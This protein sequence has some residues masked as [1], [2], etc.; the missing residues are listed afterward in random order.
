MKKAMVLVVVLVMMVQGAF[1]SSN[2]SVDGIRV[3]SEKMDVFYFKVS[4]EL[5]GAS[6][7]VIDPNGKQILVDQVDNRKVLIDFYAEPSGEYTIHI[8]KDS[9]DVSVVYNK[10]SATHAERVEAGYVSINQ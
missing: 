8:K 6:I 9:K 1:A 10:V 2:Q 7:E 3:I 5:V 4:E